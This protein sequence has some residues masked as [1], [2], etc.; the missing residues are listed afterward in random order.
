LIT[1]AVLGS[2]RPVDGSP[3]YETARQVG[4]ELARRGAR[5]LCGGYGGTMEAACRG[6]AE[7]G[8]RSVGVLLA[9]AGAGNRWLTE[10]V[11]AADL[12]E[13]LRRLRDDADAW[14]VLPR[15][16]GT[17]LELVWIGESVVKGFAR[18]R[19]LVLLGAF[20]ASVLD[21]IREEAA[22]PG[23]AAL[24]RVI[25]RAETPAEA[26]ALSFDSEARFR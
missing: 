11:V 2:S 17:L 24:A 13:R 1:I 21:T 26:V 23:A 12:S 9:G 4:R 15:G 20:W 5:V 19:P 25:R 16:L 8:G 14:I 10:S 22:G 3:E 7:G 18:P 6:A